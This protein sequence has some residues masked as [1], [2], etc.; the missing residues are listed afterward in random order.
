MKVEELFEM[1]TA[2]VLDSKSR[3]ELQKKFPPKYPDF[4]GHHVTL[5]F[6]VPKDTPNPRQPDTIEVVGYKDDGKGVEAL[7]IAING[8]SERPDGSTYHITW[9]IDK[10]AGRKPVDSNKVL[11]GGFDKV[12]STPIDITPEVLK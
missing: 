11:K 3:R 12:E 6:G 10:S 5:K 1:Y 8:K 9:S 7:V 2:L 4:I